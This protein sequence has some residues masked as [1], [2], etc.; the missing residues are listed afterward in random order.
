MFKPTGKGP[1]M[2]HGCWNSS[3]LPF[4]NRQAQRSLRL[5]RTL[6]L[7]SW[8]WTVRTLDLWPWRQSIA[9]KWS[10]EEMSRTHQNSWSCLIGPEHT[11][12]CCRSI[13][14]SHSFIESSGH[15]SMRPDL[16]SKPT[17]FLLVD[18]YPITVT[19]FNP[20]NP[21]KKVT[22]LTT[23]QEANDRVGFLEVVANQ[24]GV[25]LSRGQVRSQLS[26]QNRSRS[27]LVYRYY[28][29]RI[30][31]SAPKKSSSKSSKVKSMAY[32]LLSLCHGPEI[33]TSLTSTDQQGY[34]RIVPIR[35]QTSSWSAEAPSPGEPRSTSLSVCETPAGPDLSCETAPSFQ[36]IKVRS[37]LVQSLNQH[38]YLYICIYI[39]ITITLWK[40]YSIDILLY[41]CLTAKSGKMWI[42]NK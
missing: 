14:C 21:W 36:P 16:T 12:Q 15:V 17:P 9:F 24:T 4:R 31:K 29:H 5:Q 19:L 34:I 32:S 6:L 18:S 28:T 8:S 26:M 41:I 10:M 25:V 13:A 37:I 22:A 30:Q 3:S 2:S 20:Y 27:P 7:Q 35:K 33:H 42:E 38:M 40:Y 23:W 1:S 11:C 39:Y